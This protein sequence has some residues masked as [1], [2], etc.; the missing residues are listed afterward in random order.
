MDEG[1]AVLIAAFL[2]IGGVFLN[3][4]QQ[5]ML[6]RKQHTHAVL[7]KMNYWKEFDEGLEFAHSLSKSK[8]I[9]KICEQDR[10][11]CEKLDFILNHYEFLSAAII[12]GDIDEGLVKRVEMDR[13]TRM[14]FKFIYYI[15]AVRDDKG[16][17]LI[18]TDLEFMTYRWA[19]AGRDP[20]EALVNRVMLRPSTS[21]YDSDREAIRS[22]LKEHARTVK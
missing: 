13:L 1:V 9:L 10:K 3:S 11:E 7:D 17:E 22:R 14:Y 16:S 5:R 8:R 21:S 2:A 12:S 6:L 15:E 19:V 4:R 20:M 18:W